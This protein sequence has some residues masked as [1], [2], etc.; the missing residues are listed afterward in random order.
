MDKAL[1]AEPAYADAWA[2]RGLL[3]LRKRE[4]DVAEKDLR[5]CLELAPANYLGNLHLLALY[6]RSRD[7]RQEE[8]ARRVEELSAKREQ[9]AE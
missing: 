3:H 8:Q 4:L 5:R 6:Q 7:P 1:Q 2:E 9:Q